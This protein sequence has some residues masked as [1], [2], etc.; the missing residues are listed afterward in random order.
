MVSVVR[1]IRHPRDI[2]E[3]FDAAA[4][5]DGL[6]NSDVYRGRL[7]VWCAPHAGQRVSVQ[8]FCGLFEEFENDV[9]GTDGVPPLDTI[10]PAETRLVAA[11]Y[12][13]ICVRRV[14]ATDTKVADADES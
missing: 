6:R 11:L 8:E 2:A 3:R 5:T 13:A 9:M 1:T 14:V 10:A 4:R 7:A 12:A